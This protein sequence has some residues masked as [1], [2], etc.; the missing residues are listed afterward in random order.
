V[1]RA[2]TKGDH[3]LLGQLTLHPVGPDSVAQGA[4]IPGVTVRNLSAGAHSSKAGGSRA[5]TPR[6]KVRIGQKSV[7][8]PGLVLN[9]D[10]C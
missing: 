9:P 1:A 7:L 6:T 2:E 4:E 3:V 5:R 8:D 10:L